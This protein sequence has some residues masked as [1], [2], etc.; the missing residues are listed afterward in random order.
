MT[1]LSIAR[2]LLFGMGFGVVFFF[3]NVYYKIFLQCYLINCNL[4]TPILKDRI[5]F[6]S[7]FFFAASIEKNIPG[8]VSLSPQQKQITQRFLR[9]IL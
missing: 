8:L 9:L 6:F 2:I 4:W 1:M 7:Q 3:L 5:L